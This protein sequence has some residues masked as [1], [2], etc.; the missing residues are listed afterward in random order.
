MATFALL[1]AAVVVVALGL[2]QVLRVRVDG[3]DV[4]W[5][6]GG[7]VAGDERHA[8]ER[9]LARHRR[10]RAVGGMVGVVFASV[11]GA[12]LVGEVT[13]GIGQGHPLGDLLFCGLAGVVVGALS[14]ETFRLSDPPSST[15][16]ASLAAREEVAPARTLVAARVGLVGAGALSLLVMLLGHGAAAFW[17]AVTGTLVA[18][19]AEATLT[20]IRSRR[21]PVLSDRAHAVDLR[22]RGFAAA[23]VA[24][25]ELALAVLVAGW[26]VALLPLEGPAAVVQV[27]LVLSALVT[28]VVVLHRASPRPPRS[29]REPV[30]PVTAVR[31]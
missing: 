10:H 8:Y 31:A 30:E 23:V 17:V 2:T 7:P 4:A 16:S 3:R 24:R 14:A 1:L 26:V 11:V 27:L 6:A 25:L 19:V 9:Y 15:V 18:G 29:W 20:A 5:L 12:R 13:L 28:T 22:M 21:R